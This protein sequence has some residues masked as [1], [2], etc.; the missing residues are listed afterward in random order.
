MSADAQ[1]DNEVTHRDLLR[2]GFGPASWCLDMASK[3]IRDVSRHAR[4]RTMRRILCRFGFLHSKPRSVPHRP[5][6]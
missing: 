5:L 3:M 2:Y 1:E 6:R 4:P